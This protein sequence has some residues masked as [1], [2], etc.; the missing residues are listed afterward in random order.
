MVA[1]RI[2][3]ELIP[4]GTMPYRAHVTDAAWDCYVRTVDIV[5]GNV[6]RCAL[7]FRLGLPEGWFADVRARSSIYKTGLILCNG[8]GVVDAGYRGEVMAFFYARP[9]RELP[10]V[11]SR[12][13]Q[14]MIRRLD[15]ADL[16]LV[17]SVDMDTSRGCGGFGSTGR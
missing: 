14:M 1:E 4:G 2:D 10:V 9:A 16:C 6:I 17:D 15:A 7:G 8:C 11:G 5:E 13:V 3:I 12:V